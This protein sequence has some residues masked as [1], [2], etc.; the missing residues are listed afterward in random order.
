M[1][2]KIKLCAL[3]TCLMHM[4]DYIYKKIFLCQTN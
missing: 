4:A 1:T 2:V 3:E